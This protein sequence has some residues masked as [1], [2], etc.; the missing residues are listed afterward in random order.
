MRIFLAGQKQFGRDV[1]T[2]LLASA[3]T[4]TGVSAPLHN[5]SGDNT[6]R[7]RDLATQE[8]IPVIPTAEAGDVDLIIAAHSHEFIG[9]RARTRT[10]LGAIGY[11]PSLLPRHRGRDAVRWTIKMRDPI[12]GGSVFWL[13]DTVDGGDVAAQDWC[14]VRPDDDARELWRRDLAPMGVRLLARALADI[15]SG[16]LVRV[17]Q[18]A[19]LATWEPS[20][21]RPPLHRPDMPLLGDGSDRL[22]RSGFSVLRS[23]AGVA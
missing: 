6:D 7:L 5:E 22:A 10:T 3:H 23:F 17:P 9:R 1:L 20:W 4:V 21:Q 16:V 15:S 13:S 19:T 11:H 8:R 2:M 14:F 12:A 18:D